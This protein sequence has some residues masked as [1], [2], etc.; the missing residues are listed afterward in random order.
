MPP[1]AQRLGFAQLGAADADRAGR[2]LAAGDLDA[3]VGLGVRPQRHAARPRKAAIAAMLRSSASRSISSAGVFSAAREPC[4]PIKWAVEIAHIHPTA[5]SWAGLSA[6]SNEKANSRLQMP[7]HELACGSTRRLTAPQRSA[8]D[9]AAAHRRSSA[10]GAWPSAGARRAP[11]NTASTPA[12]ASATASWRTGGSEIE[13]QGP[14]FIGESQISSP[15]TARNSK[16]K[17]IGSRRRRTSAIASRKASGPRGCGNFAF[18]LLEADV[19]LG[20]KDAPRR[21]RARG[22]P[23]AAG[24]QPLQD[25]RR[26][27]EPLAMSQAA[28]NTA[29]EASGQARDRRPRRP[30]PGS[31]APRGRRRGRRRTRRDGERQRARPIAPGLPPDGCGAGSPAGERPGR[32]S[33]SPAPS[34]P[35]CPGRAAPPG[36]SPARARRRTPP[37]TRRRRPAEIPRQRWRAIPRSGRCHGCRCRS[38]RR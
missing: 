2:D 15:A 32:R 17:M 9:R 36:R 28:W 11:W 31:S 22:R 14:A 34:R 27:L 1:V 3:L 25:G 16:G 19:A 10:C 13:T 21:S 6:C 23:D 20:G 37:S 38:R 35:A 12:N 26:S 18:H 29:P 24:Q 4:W 7:V 30:R 8:W 5:S 33:A